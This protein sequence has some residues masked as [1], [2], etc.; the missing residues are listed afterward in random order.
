MRN[1]KAVK[2]YHI[3]LDANGDVVEVDSDDV[4]IQDFTHTVEWFDS[5]AEREKDPRVGAWRAERRKSE[6]MA[7]DVNGQ[8]TSQEYSLKSENAT[9]WLANNPEQEDTESIEH[10]HGDYTEDLYMWLAL[11]VEL[12]G[13]SPRDAA[14]SIIAA[15]KRDQETD[16]GSWER[17]KQRIMTREKLKNG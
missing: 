6:R 12:A 9:R 10:T 15:V 17:A 8:K 2:P 4:Q 5:I 14:E 7:E 11:E 16:M 13:K 1:I 3:I